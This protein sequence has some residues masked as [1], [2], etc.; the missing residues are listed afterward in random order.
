LAGL[1]FVL[2]LLGKMIVFSVFGLLF[3]IFGKSI[4]TERI[5]GKTGALL[6]GIAFSLGFC[7]TMLWIFFGLVMPVTLSSSYGYILSSVFA[8]GT[9]FPLLLFFALLI[10]FGLGGIVIRK[11]K[12]IGG[13]MYKLSGVLLIVLGVSDTITYWTL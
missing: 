6:L 8:L 5:G 7:P 11:M 2:Y 13:W 12:M 1:E 3:W 9:A 10:G 4:S